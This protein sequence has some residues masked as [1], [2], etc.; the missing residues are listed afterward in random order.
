MRR[1]VRGIFAVAVIA[2]FQS[3]S[4][5]VAA[6]APAWPQARSDIPADPAVL[7]GTLPNGMR[8]AIMKNATP[9]DEVSIRLRI[10]AGSLMESDAQ[11]GLAHFLEHMA[12]R[13][14]THLPD[15]NVWEV[16]QKL[17]LRTGADANANT[18]Q[19]QTVF[20][21]DLPQNDDA[22]IDQGLMLTRDITSELS[23]KPEAF[24][25]E[26]G[27][28]LS[29]ERLRASPGQRSFEAQGKFLLRGQLA[30]VRLPIG[31]VDIIRNAPV[32]L[33]ADF[34]RAFYRPERTVLIVVGDIDP[35]A[36]KAKILAR[37]SDWNPSGAGRGDPDPGMPAIRGSEYQVFSEPGAPQYLSVSWVQPFDPRPDTVAHRRENLIE[38]L[39]LTIL[40]QRFAA[41]AQNDNAPFTSAGV[42]RGNSVRSAR[43]ASLR[44]GYSGDKWQ[45]ALEEAE[46]IRRQVV[47]QGVSQQE[48][49]RETRAM[50][51]NAAANLEASPTRQSRNLAQGLVGSIDRDYVFS[52]PQTDVA[53][54]RQ[55]IQGITADDVNG[56]L[57]AVFTGNGPLVFLSSPAPVDGG[58]TALA[59]VFERAESAAVEHT[60]PPQV[61]AWPYT[62]FGVPGRVVET[63]HI[64]DLDTWFIRFENG[65]RLTVKPTKFRANQILVNVN[66]A[67]GDLA[68]PRDRTV[69]NPNA[70][71]SGGLQ[72]MSWLDIR[73]T[74]EGKVANVALGIE[75][76]LFALSGG[77][78]PEDLDTELQLITAYITSPG[79]RQEPY[80]QSLTSLS[81]SLPKLDTSPMSLFTAKLPEL[82]HPGDAR[83]AYPTL[84][85]VQNAN[86]AQV[87]AVIVPALANNALEV[88]IVGDIGVDQ[89]VNSVAATLGALP[90]RLGAK[91]PLPQPG[92][93]HFPAP[94]AQPVVLY[95]SGRADQGAAAIAWQTT[96]LYS[97]HE[98]AARGMLKD[99]LQLRMLDELRIRDGATYSPAATA[100]ASRIFPGYGYIAAF[101]EI[102]PGKSQLF[103][104]T[105]QKI[106]ADLRDH[107]PDPD[108]LERARKPA[109]DAL[110]KAQLTNNF[111]AGSL[112]GAQFDERRLAYLR[113]L[114][115]QTRAVTAAD[116][117][118]VAQKYLRDDMAWKLVIAPRPAQNAPSATTPG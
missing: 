72:A 64:D 78:R 39:A 117:Q 91:P 3:S 8:Y 38:N 28:V 116:V 32:S 66:L 5:V 55:N 102:P 21:F 118:R 24:D 105:V 40:N 15:G 115:P 31:K 58:Q 60:A 111:W 35:A 83:W 113:Q 12:F 42:T 48:L 54:L 33:V 25:A 18:G 1:F 93:V 87:Q 17:G 19:T 65:V 110:E 97:D 73:R 44:I 63:R 82:L 23:L 34:Y 61:A 79:W 94:T 50:L 26:R 29:E 62:N 81:D 11:Q 95:H 77:T 103:F 10:G 114:L 99:I 69:L 4:G 89:A 41:V 27:P 67:G 2:V 36:I 112:S 7:F 108:Y 47:A 86:L 80:R 14:S 76:D 45:T 101:A 16:L 68:F 57:R 37:F 92:E 106:A 9:K 74:L 96:D 107:G 53:L 46:K 88:T 84:N 56:A 100:S 109:I 71:V 98:S 104:D 30:S 22:T 70:W 59:T 6:D 51:A 20:Q 90:V 52:S 49:D 85:D 13:G 75:D 43:I